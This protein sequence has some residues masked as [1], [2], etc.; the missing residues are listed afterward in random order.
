MPLTSIYRIG[1]GD[2]LDIRILNYEVQTTSTLYTVLGGGLLEYPLVGNPLP[3]AGM[4]TNEIDEQLTAE[5]KRREVFE[6]PQV[7]VSV[8][9]YNSH[10]ATVTGM[11]ENPGA[12]ILRRE[13][14]PLYVVLAEAVPCSEAGQ[15]VITTPATGASRTIDLADV[16]ASNSLVHAGDVL[17]VMVRPAQFFYIGGHIGA[18]GQKD[19]HAG[20][21]LTQA[22]LA[23][24]GTVRVS[25]VRGSNVR[26]RIA[27]QGQ[28]GRLVSSE[29]NLNDIEA[30]EVPDP[31]IQAGDRI[32]LSRK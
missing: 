15:V 32:E 12:K 21:T 8:R 11:V 24:G 13:A 1:E 28:D 2:I 9:D 18:P 26:V 31:M 16:I 29:Y 7:V 20:L 25:N 4:T 3:V 23:A 30:G 10:T 22:I 5:L 14:L 19:F 6:S 17:R 27:R